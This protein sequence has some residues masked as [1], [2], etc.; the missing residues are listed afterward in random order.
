MFFLL[1]FQIDHIIKVQC[2]NFGFD[3][4]FRESGGRGG[5]GTW[6]WWILGSVPDRRPGDRAPERG[7]GR[8]A[9]VHLAIASG[10]ESRQKLAG[11]VHCLGPAFQ[12]LRRCLC[13]L[14]LGP[15][16]PA[17]TRPAQDG[18]DRLPWGQLGPSHCPAVLDQQ[19]ACFAHGSRYWH[20]VGLAP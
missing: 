10:P 16:R 5:W 12:H 13:C 3:F 17:K 11:M 15:H 18:G 20:G 7:V 8:P 19:P 4:G 2:S 6:T 1:L 14:G 9:P